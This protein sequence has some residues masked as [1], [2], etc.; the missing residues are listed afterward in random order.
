MMKID[1]NAPNP[2]LQPAASRKAEQRIGPDATTHETT[3]T[4]DGDTVRLSPQAQFVDRALQAASATP[5]IRQDKVE[6]ARQKL[7]AG[8]IG[9]DADRL[10]NKLIDS[11]LEG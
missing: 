11:L 9:A 6:Q 2:D 10:A 3:T 4:A 7:A 5:A 8:E 1:R